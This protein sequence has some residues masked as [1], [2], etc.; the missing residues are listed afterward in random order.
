MKKILFF[1]SISYIFVAQAQHPNFALAEKKFE[2]GYLNERKYYV[3]F[4]QEYF[5]NSYTAYHDAAYL[6][7]DGLKKCVSGEKIYASYN[8]MRC[9]YAEAEVFNAMESPKKIYDLYVPTF[10][11]LIP[12]SAFIHYKQSPKLQISKTNFDSI[13]VS[14]LDILYNASILVKRELYTIKCGSLLLPH[15]KKSF[16]KY[17]DVLYHVIIASG[18]VAEADVLLYHLEL[19]THKKDKPIDRNADIL[20]AIESGVSRHPDSFTEEQIKTL[21]ELKKKL[22]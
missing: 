12:D 1:F 10:D 9:L 15:Y 19:W 6:Y 16:E 7:L 17:N 13:W 11:K 5:V 2:E 4:N 21:D 14:T 18:N 22:S 8:A 3:N 20:K